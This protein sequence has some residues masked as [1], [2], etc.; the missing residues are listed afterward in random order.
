MWLLVPDDIGD[1]P[2]CEPEA[3]QAATNLYSIGNGFT[4][5]NPSLPYFAFIFRTES[6][7]AT[8]PLAGL[9]RH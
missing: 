1:N 5:D 9:S 7:P 4:L 3:V 2:L 8:F 6:S